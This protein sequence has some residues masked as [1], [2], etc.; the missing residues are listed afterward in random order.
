MRFYAC[1]DLHANTFHIRIIGENGEKGKEANSYRDRHANRR[2]EGPGMKIKIKGYL[3][4]LT[5]S[6][7]MDLRRW[8]YHFGRFVAISELGELQSTSSY[9][10]LLPLHQV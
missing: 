3:C 2:K 5:G 6:L 10:G 8:G 4:L 9:L 1:I 7:S